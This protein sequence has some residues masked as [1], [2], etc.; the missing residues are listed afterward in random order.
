MNLITIFILTERPPFTTMCSPMNLNTF[1]PVARTRRPSPA[2][3]AIALL[4]AAA[5]CMALPLHKAHE[6]TG[7]H[8]PVCAV[9]HVV[10]ALL[11]G[12]AAPCATESARTLPRLRW[13]GQAAEPLRAAP[14]TTLVTQKTKLST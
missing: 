3:A 12:M 13:G 8:C 10:Q 5:L 9:L 6:C 4:L 7:E 14:P 1:L 2:Y 11:A